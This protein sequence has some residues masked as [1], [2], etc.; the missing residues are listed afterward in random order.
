MKSLWIMILAIIATAVTM[1]IFY[2]K[3][4]KDDFGVARV[5]ELNALITKTSGIASWYQGDINQKETELKNLHLLLSGALNTIS[6]ATAERNEI[7]KAIYYLNK[8]L[9]RDTVKEAT[10]LNNSTGA[11]SN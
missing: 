10:T 5:A 11:L 1:W 2:N 9:W 8:S 7:E 6:G 4:L 3:K